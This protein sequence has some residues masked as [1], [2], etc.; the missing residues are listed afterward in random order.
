LLFDSKFYR[1]AYPDIG[2]ADALRHFVTTGAFEGRD[3]HPLF[4]TDFY[5]EQLTGP[6]EINALCDYLDRG[7]ALGLKPHRMFDGEFYARRYPDV[8]ESGMNPLVHYILHG[9]A[10]GRKPHPL[11]EPEYYVASCPAARDALNPLVYFLTHEADGMCRPHPLFDG[12]LDNLPSLEAPQGMATLSMMDVEIPI[13]HPPHTGAFFEC[14]RADQLAIN[15][16]AARSKQKPTG[17][18]PTGP[19]KPVS[20]R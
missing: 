16:S 3:P 7:A 8:L 10:E 11:F 20:A 2:D 17:P 1:E 15:S 18:S 4:D 12:N 19:P 9:A 6:P 5:L 13:E 14:V